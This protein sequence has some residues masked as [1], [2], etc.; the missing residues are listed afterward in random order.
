MRGDEDIVDDAEHIALAGIT[1]AGERLAFLGVGLEGSG[2][3]AIEAG[4]LAAEVGIVLIFGESES[5]DVVR[6]AVQERDDVMALD[7]FVERLALGLIPPGAASAEVEVHR[8]HDRFGRADLGQPRTQEGQAGF[9]I[10][11]R[12]RLGAFL[13][14]VAGIQVDV[15]EVHALP[16]PSG[17]QGIGGKLRDETRGEHTAI[18]FAQALTDRTGGAAVVIAR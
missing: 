5:G 3:E 15:D 6:M 10:P 7:D 1:W 17:V 4:A 14:A 8:D 18:T 11:H 9:R 2:G 13:D 12:A 16:V